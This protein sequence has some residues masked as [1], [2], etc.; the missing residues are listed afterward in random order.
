[1]IVLILA[2]GGGTRLWPV[3]REDFPKQFL[4]FGDGQ[5][6]L[7]KTVLRFLQSPRVEKILISTH[8]HY[9][10]LVEKQIASIAAKERIEILVEPF[11]KNT[12]PAI[13]YAASFLAQTKSPD[14]VLV[15][16]PADHWIEPESVFLRTLEEIEPFAAE[17]K[18]FLFGIPPQKPE[19][20][21]GY[22]QIG[23]PI[24]PGFYAVKRFVEKPSLPLAKQLL[25]QGDTYWNAGIFA[26]SLNT[27]WKELALYQP[28]LFALSNKGFNTLQE[29]FA[30]V[31]EVSFDY[32]ILE[33]SAEI[34]ICPLPVSWSDVGSWDSVY[35]VLEKDQNQNVKVG[36]VAEYETKN[37]LIF[38]KDRF[39]STVGLEDLLIIQTEEAT[40]IG[41]RGESQR[42]K[43][44]VQE[45]L[46]TKDPTTQILLAQ[47]PSYSIQKRHLLPGQQEIYRLTE[48]EIWIGLKGKICWEEGSLEEGQSCLFWPG[49]QLHCSNLQNA[50]GIYLCI[51]FF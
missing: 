18:L 4:H 33:R 39:I 40:F 16:A 25:E 50:P 41:K 32:A 19:T 51:R 46:Q 17:G 5:S 12:A 3:S 30:A 23:S 49:Q 34:A 42:V 10:A 31:P 20:G 43:N 8:L 44:V 26:F 6:L 24:G 15:V 36:R 2:G 9:K 35:E 28:D 7:Q 38:A 45:W 47:T 22:I 13:T 1:M 21:Y 11:R 14:T 37:S 29:Q 48:K 27:F